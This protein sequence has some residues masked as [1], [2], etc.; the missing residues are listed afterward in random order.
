MIACLYACVA[1]RKRTVPLAIN[2]L[3]RIFAACENDMETVV[4]VRE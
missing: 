3:A 2:R 4:F 1:A